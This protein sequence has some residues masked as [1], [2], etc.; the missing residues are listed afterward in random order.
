MRHLDGLLLHPVQWLL[1]DEALGDGGGALDP[2]IA[3]DAVDNARKTL[4]LPGPVNTLALPF[5]M[6]LRASA[7]GALRLDLETASD[8]DLA[9]NGT[10]RLALAFTV[11]TDA[12]VGGG[13]SVDLR[14]NLPDVPAAPDLWD[15]LEI[16][17]GYDGGQFSLKLGT[18][19][20]LIELLPFAGWDAVLQG[21]GGVVRKLLPTMVK[22]A[23]DALD[24]DAALNSFVTDLR[25]AAAALQIDSE[26]G[27]QTLT[28]DPVGWLQ[29]RFSAANAAASATA[30]FDLLN[31]NGNGLAGIADTGSGLL[32]YAPAGLSLG[33]KEEMKMIGVWVSLNGLATGPLT[34][35]LGAHVAIGDT[36]DLPVDFGVNLDMAVDPGVIQPGGVSIEPSLHF[37][38]DGAWDLHLYPLGD[39]LGSSN[40]C[41][42]ILPSFQF[43]C[44]GG[45]GD[46]GK[47]L[48]AFARR[49]LVPLAVEM[50]LDN[51]TVKGWLNAPLVA[52]LTQPDPLDELSNA[53]RPG[54]ILTAVGLLASDGGDG[55]NLVGIDNVAFPTPEQA[56][57]RLLGEGLHALAAALGNTAL[58]DLS[59]HGQEGGI[60]LAHRL[61][62][63]GADPADLYGLRLLMPPRQLSSDPEVRLFLGDD[64]KWISQADGTETEGLEGGINLFL[65]RKE[66]DDF[67]FHMSLSMVGVGID[68]SGRND[69]PL[70]EVSGFF[71]GGVGTRLYLALDDVVTWR[72]WRQ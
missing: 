43:R 26:P 34:T 22:A 62:D 50:F 57:T 42:D 28:A 25:A 24:A 4:G 9:G 49:V 11:A 46:M 33:R 21:A 2:T 65:L 19:A 30:L 61:D 5:G 29:G 51:G 27:L 37:A 23:V 10:L 56:I 59:N 14:F 38:Y 40:F 15:Q 35:G 8:L 64:A 55:Y 66:G 36:P 48:M 58:V 20:V 13:G 17:A 3:L 12:R 41:L 71:L 53:T 6:Q 1:S 7:P 32:T 31:N 16:L 63:S 68:F 69:T 67:S 70:L 44:E 54:A 39:A 18:D 47:C 52:E 60:Y 72:G 45:D